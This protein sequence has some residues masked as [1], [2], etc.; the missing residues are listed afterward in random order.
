MLPLLLLFFFLLRTGVFFFFFFTT[1]FFFLPPELFTLVF[2]FFPLVLLI[3]FFF[4]PP[5]FFFFFFPNAGFLLFFTP[6]FPPL[7][8][9]TTFSRR[10]EPASL[11]RDLSDCFKF[12]P[13]RT[14][15]ARLSPDCIAVRFA[16]LITC[17][18]TVELAAFLPILKS[19]A[20]RGISFLNIFEMKETRV[21]FVNVTRNETNV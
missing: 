8:S 9:F 5:E 3:I 6:L 12:F 21:A 1:L 11:R 14:S 7:I 16:A 19:F 4:F 18:P 10:F 15:P 17:C 13:S 20:P 2:F